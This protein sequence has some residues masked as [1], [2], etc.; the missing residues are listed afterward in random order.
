MFPCNHFKRERNKENSNQTKLSTPVR[1]VES[2]LQLLVSLEIKPTVFF[3]VFQQAKKLQAF[4]VRS[5]KQNVKIH[6]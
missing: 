4:Y 5:A 6:D 2:I 3:T 1:A